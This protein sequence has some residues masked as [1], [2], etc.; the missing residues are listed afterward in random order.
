MSLRFFKTGVI[1]FSLDDYVALPSTFFLWGSGDFLLS[2][3]L[4]RFAFSK[5]E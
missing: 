5:Q 2:E 4:C 3:R 1:F